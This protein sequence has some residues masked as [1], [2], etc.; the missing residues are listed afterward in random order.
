MRMDPLAGLGRACET[1]RSLGKHNC[2]RMKVVSTDITVFK[3]RKVTPGCTE[4][5]TSAR[6]PNRYC[7]PSGAYDI[8]YTRKLDW[9]KS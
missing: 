3:P 7:D 2:Q 1:K 8:E 5:E 6:I 4:G 9:I